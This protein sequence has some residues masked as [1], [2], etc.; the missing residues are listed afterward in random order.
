MADWLHLIVPFTS[1]SS[2]TA[3]PCRSVEQVITSPD[4]TFHWPQTDYMETASLQ[5]PC[6]AFP[7]LTKDSFAS[8]TCG[9]GGQWM[10]TDVEACVFD[11][12]DTFCKVCTEALGQPTKCIHCDK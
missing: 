4:I 9:A 10:E 3:L 1:H 6:D 11:N 7:E 12:Q 8:R 2:H 5:C